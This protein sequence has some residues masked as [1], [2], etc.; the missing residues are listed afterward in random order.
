MFKYLIR[1]KAPAPM[2]YNLR[3]NPVASPDQQNTL[4][5]LRKLLDL[6]SDERQ[7][8]IFSSVA[9]V[10]NSLLSLV[11]PVL[12]GQ[13]VD[14]YIQTKQYQ[15]VL[16]S[17]AILLLIF[18]LAFVASFIQTR[19][20]GGVGQRV[21]FRLRNTIFQKLQEL[22]ISFFN[23]NQAGD[24]ISRLNNDTD[25]LNQFFSQTLMQFIG[26][27]FIMIGSGIFL[28]YLYPRLGLAAL[29]PAL[30]LLIFT[31]LVSPW[32]KS[33]N[34]INLKTT[35]NL[36]AEVQE[37]LDNFKVIVAFNRR[38]FFQE[39]FTTVNQQNYQ[40][41]ISAGLANNIFTPVYGLSS[42]LAQLIVV[43][44]GLY[45]VS[46]A[47]FTLGMLISFLA[48]V[49]SFYSPLRQLAALCANFQLALASWDRITEIISLQ[50]D[51][52]LQTTSQSASPKPENTQQPVLQF[53]QVSFAYPGGQPVLQDINFQLQAGKTYALVGPTGGGKTTIASLM[54]RLFDPTAGQVLLQDRDLR[55]YEPDDRVKKIGF[56]L[57][58]PFIFTG[59]VQEN[60][61]YGHPTFQDNS[62]QNIL[63]IL[64]QF[65]LEKLLARFSQGLDTKISGGN[66]SVS[67]GQKQL[68]AFMR[69]VLRQPEILILDEATANIDTVT[70]QLLEEIIQHL[71]STTTKIII[72]HRLNTIAA[73]DEIFFVNSGQIT[74]AGSIQQ[75]LQL[76]M[77]GQSVS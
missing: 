27:I 23:Q 69:A 37:S 47:H 30:I 25:K 31:R 44:Y 57:Q 70:E 19:L 10:A 36:S 65:G 8:L 40:S 28:V 29:V 59:T 38:Q 33:K 50:S 56:I 32:V 7:K 61:L 63:E 3:N 18:V 68:I 14:R 75:A 5:S 73:A 12:L 74:R 2:K 54:A 6:M 51:L 4:S 1:N 22:P 41:A 11:I 16:Y 49:N 53:Q 42:N 21:L 26:S 60:I 45:L 64:R 72:A 9:I 67:L 77:Q 43:F 71:P 55:S 20:M 58:E 46:T 13:A 66:D 24:L 76:L 34:A 48:Y 62:P 17:A 15:G 39:K 35:G 52:L